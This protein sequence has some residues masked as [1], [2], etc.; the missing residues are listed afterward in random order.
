M[1]SIFVFVLRCRLFYEKNLSRSALI[2][3][4][5]FTLFIPTTT[6][7]LFHGTVACGD[8]RRAQSIISVL[9]GA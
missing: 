6:I 4:T 2:S 3:F 5:P 9:F 7:S 1:Y 8:R